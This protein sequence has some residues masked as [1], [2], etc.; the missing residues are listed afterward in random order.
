M[1]KAPSDFLC[2]RSCA[3][4][5]DSGRRACFGQTHVAVA[6][7]VGRPPRTRAEKRVCA[8]SRQRRSF[9][10]MRRRAEDARLGNPANAAF[11]LVAAV[12]SFVR[13]DE[14]AAVRR[15]PQCGSCGGRLT[16]IVGLALSGRSKRLA[17]GAAFRR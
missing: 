17:T 4:V 2:A 6:E 16:L 8:L 3:H 13:I 5:S 7:V 14:V 10:G 9:A 15:P 11:F 1:D 12:L